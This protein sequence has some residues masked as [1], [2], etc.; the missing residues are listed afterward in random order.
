MTRPVT[1]SRDVHLLGSWCCSVR[2]AVLLC[3]GG[4]RRLLWFFGLVGDRLLSVVGD[5]VRS[6][7][8]DA[9]RVGHCLLSVVGDRLLSVVGDA[10]VGIRT[11]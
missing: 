2:S 3:C 8:G 1:G 7:V 5:A 10:L 4:T 11:R 6:V 9:V